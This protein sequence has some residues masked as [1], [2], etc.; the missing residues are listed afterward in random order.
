M[1][2]IYAIV[3]AIR[4]EKG[5]SQEEVAERI[6]MTQGNYGRLE[7][8]QTQL[9]IERLEQLADVFGMSVSSIM[10]Y[11]IGESINKEDFQYY[12]NLCQKLE[13]QIAKLK[14]DIEYY[15]E[16]SSNDFSKLEKAK[17]LHKNEVKSLKEKI[18]LKDEIIKER[19]KTIED[20]NRMISILE[21]AF[22]KLGGQNN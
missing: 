14:S 10:S 19:D 21:K 22:D 8:G 2:K 1:N 4:T 13:K 6:G 3:K 9:T 18:I 11:E 5:L 15:D 16:E 7:R 20:K 12:F 17:E